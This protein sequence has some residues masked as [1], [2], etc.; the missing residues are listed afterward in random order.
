MPRALRGLPLF[1][2][3]RYAQARQRLRGT[4][5]E[6]IA[7]RRV[8]GDGEV[9]LRSL[10]LAEDA[11]NGGGPAGERSL[12]DSEVSDQVLTFFTAGMETT[13]NLMGW[14]MHLLARHQDVQR[15]L[16][17]EASEVTGGGPTA[18]EHLV[19]LEFT[20]AVLRETLRLYPLALR[21]LGIEGVR[22][23]VL[24]VLGERGCDRIL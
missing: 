2:N 11:A 23:D 1:G 15:R 18:F 3:H 4:L 14:A 22:G 6:V 17:Q 10:L 12:S 13:G 24:E 8:A 5:G 9:S 16:W 21:V 7:R 19:S 20:R